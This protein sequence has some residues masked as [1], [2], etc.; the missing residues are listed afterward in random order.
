VA[1]LL[2]GAR[3]RVRQ[4]RAPFASGHA[5]GLARSRLNK[6]CWTARAWGLCRTRDGWRTRLRRPPPS[7]P[8]PT[9]CRGSGHLAEVAVWS[10]QT[11]PPKRLEALSHFGQPARRAWPKW[12]RR[13]APGGAPAWAVAGR[14]RTP[15][16]H[17]PNLPGHPLLQR[18]ARS[19]QVEGRGDFMAK[20]EIRLS[21]RCFRLGLQSPSDQ[22]QQILRHGAALGGGTLLEALIRVGWHIF[23]NHGRPGGGSP[24]K[25]G[26]QRLR[27]RVSPPLSANNSTCRL[28]SFS[29]VTRTSAG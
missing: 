19:R 25:V 15:R 24:V 5:H 21:L 6:S 9:A 27:L 17:L 12:T 7:P 22:M 13:S 10:A 26:V 11:T 2:F 14:D 16:R 18:A 28:D 29:L 1:S 4:A 23:E 20:D 8:A 3:R